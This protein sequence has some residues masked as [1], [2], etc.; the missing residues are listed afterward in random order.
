LIAKSEHNQLTIKKDVSVATLKDMIN[1]KEML[2]Q[3]MEE[4]IEEKL[5]LEAENN[6]MDDHLN[7][8]SEE[9]KKACLRE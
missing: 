7:H 5:L 2:N 6:K 9:A 4:T 1:K 8:K 3:Q